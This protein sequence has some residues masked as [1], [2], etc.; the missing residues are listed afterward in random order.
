MKRV[1]RW[2]DA[3][4]RHVRETVRYKVEPV[5]PLHDPIMYRYYVIPRNRFLNF[6]LHYMRRSDVGDLHDHRMANITILLQGHYYEERFVSRPIAGQEL[7]A[8]HKSVVEPRR[9]L[10]RWASTPHRI[11][12]GDD[13]K[14]KVWSLFVG[15]PHVRNWGFW[16]TTNDIAHWIPHEVREPGKPTAA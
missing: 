13:A 5:G 11:V 2:I 9:P 14:E 1:E 4:I 3:G 7:P 15:F 10:F 12:L 16:T 6:Y 8:T